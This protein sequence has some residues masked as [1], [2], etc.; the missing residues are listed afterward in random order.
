MQ[1]RYHGVDG[2]FAI[3]QTPATKRFDVRLDTAARPSPDRMADATE[4]V[5]IDGRFVAVFEGRLVNRR[6]LLAQLTDSG[7]L[8]TTRSD[9]ELALG[10]YERY[11]NE[12]F[13]RLD[14]A[15]ALVI[16]DTRT[17]ELILVRDRIGRQP[18]YYGVDGD[19]LRFGTNLAR[20]VD[21]SSRRPA[22]NRQ[23]L[24]AYL[25]LTYIP[26]PLTI[27]E[28][29][30][31]LLP[32]TFL[33]VGPAGPGHPQTYW[34]LDYGDAN[35]IQDHA[36]CKTMLRD[37]LFGSVEGALDSAGHA[38]TLLS[39]GIDSTIITG[40]ASQV[41]GR[42]V[43]TFTIGF[44]DRGYDES[45]RA[46]LA[47]DLHRT[48]HHLITLDHADVLP[49]LDQLILNLDEPYG[50]SSY[51]AAS[52]VAQAARPH[53]ET[54]LTGDGGDELFAG[55]SK[56]LIGHYS[57]MLS[58]VPG[59]VSGAAFK[60]A[61][62]VLPSQ[63]SLLRK[64]NKV[65]S[66]ATLERFD[67][68]L[69]LMSLGFPGEQIDAVMPGGNAEST[70]ALIRR[71]YNKFA[72][73][74]DEMRRALYL[75]FK[76]VLEGDMLPKAYYSSRPFGLHISPPMFG[77]EVVEVAAQI[78]SEFKINGGNTKAILKETFADLIPPKLLT[79]SKRGFSVPLGSWL[80]QGMR[81]SL[82]EALSE[83]RIRDEGV[84]DYPVAS[85]LLN[86]HFAG[87]SDHSSKLWALYVL[88]VWREA[89]R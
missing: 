64:I 83:E 6:S 73:N 20:V 33:R 21:A 82:T 66:A 87:H 28:G 65:A 50:D 31:K 8:S 51:I 61:N 15:F 10:C 13:D 11:G 78:P 62:A 72:D 16:H 58:R 55:Y 22:M 30:S 24:A 45:A 44:D 56:Y 25:Q 48:R 53:V 40:I 27:Y 38:G 18:L 57:D 42:S 43:D 75:D 46:Q 67:Q 35:R 52:A 86:E 70:R 9:A 84:L 76:V 63:S 34:D 7:Y 79:A 59:W 19:R 47:A 80:R 88:S 5:S 49:Q 26:A 36:R 4:A 74:A 81:A 32:G 69:S 29:I 1:P 3:G 60:S 23:A 85:G 89:N 39:G 68:R 2:S 71:Y 12:G 14:G 41:L 77:R 37:A 54:V 17:E